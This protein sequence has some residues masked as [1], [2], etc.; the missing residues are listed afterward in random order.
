MLRHACRIV[1]GKTRLI[2]LCAV[3]ALLL[4]FVTA[5]MADAQRP[6][7]RN[8]TFTDPCSGTVYTAFGCCT[9][10]SVPAC[11]LELELGG[12]IVGVRVVCLGLP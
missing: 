2:A 4:G 7:C 3:L 10:P 12:C 9:L 6:N 1:K 8:C 5:E 11:L